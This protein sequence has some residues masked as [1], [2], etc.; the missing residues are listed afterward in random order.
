M[1]SGVGLGTFSVDMTGTND[2]QFKWLPAAGIG[3]TVS[4]FATLVGVA[5]TVPGTGIPG[6]TYEIGDTALRCTRTEIAAS[7]SP[8]AETIVTTSGNSYTSSKILVEIHN[9]TDNE[10]SFFH[11]AAN[12]Y[13]EDVNYIKY[14]NVSTATT[15]RRDIQNT[16]MISSGVDGILR[17]TPQENK[18]Y[19]VRTSEISI[20]RPDGA[21]EDQLIPL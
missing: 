1:D 13:A 21:P 18:A 2:L 7:G 14:N 19:I 10:Y 6:T 3:I 12:V 16:D 17:F 8:T 20:D 4:T 11:V 9:T 5:T 15:A